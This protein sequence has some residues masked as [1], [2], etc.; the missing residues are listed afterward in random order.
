MT[1][2]VR[3][4]RGSCRPLRELQFRGSSHW[5]SNSDCDAA[6]AA[7]E[8]PIYVNWPHGFWKPKTTEQPTD[9]GERLSAWLP[10]GI[11][12]STQQDWSKWMKTRSIWILPGPRH[13]Q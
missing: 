4:N 13:R 6:T 9:Y 12:L 7:T 8:Q 5:H 11:S 2:L 10:P 1:P 3:L